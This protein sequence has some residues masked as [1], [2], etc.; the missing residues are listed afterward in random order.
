ML[1]QRAEVRIRERLDIE[2]ARQLE[3]SNRDLKLKFR[4][5]LQRAGTYPALI[6][7]SSTDDELNVV[8]LEAGWT[9]LGAPNEPPSLPGAHAI[10]IV[11]HE[12]VVNNAGNTMFSARTIHDY[13]IR[14]EVI[15]RRGSLPDDMKDDEDR[16]P[17]SITFADEQPIHFQISDGGFNLLLKF[18]Q[19]TSGERE[20]H[21]VNVAATYRAKR[22]ARDWSSFA[23]ATLVIR[24]DR[25]AEGERIPIGEVALRS[26]L[27]K[28]F[29][30]LFKERIEGEGLEM[31]GK[32][33]SLGK[34]PLGDYLM[35][36][37]WAAIGWDMP[38]QSCS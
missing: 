35:E 21:R 37:G 11:A 9:Q 26:I 5:P 27:R 31:P 32:Y 29:S 3:V 25:E 36:S 30:K 16:D 19:F 34:L 28:K 18:K 17:W 15:C 38:N 24:R 10:K 22:T 4:D 7:V 8:A 23:K 6:N 2:A 20:L 12:S 1:P 33:K 13:E 14:N